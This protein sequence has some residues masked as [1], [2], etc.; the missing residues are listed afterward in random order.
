MNPTAL[1]YLYGL[2]LHGS[3][4]MV[5]TK[6]IQARKHKTKRINKKWLKRYGFKTIEVPANRYFVMGNKRSG[7]CSGMGFAVY[8]V[9]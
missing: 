7:C 8:T 3:R 4:H 2:E 6:Q 5:D 1:G 9:S